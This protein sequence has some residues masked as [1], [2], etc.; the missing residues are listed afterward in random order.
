M[1]GGTIPDI[2]VPSD[3]FHP[4]PKTALEIKSTKKKEKRTLS[5]RIPENKEQKMRLERKSG[6]RS[7]TAD[8]LDYILWRMSGALQDI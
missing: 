8:S 4:E 6:I 2:S 3:Q 7:C 5:P 1:R